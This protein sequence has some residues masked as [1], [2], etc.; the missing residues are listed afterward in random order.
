MAHPTANVDA[1]I[2]VNANEVL[3]SSSSASLKAKYKQ[4]AK[5]I[6]DGAREMARNDPVTVSADTSQFIVTLLYSYSRMNDA[7]SEEKIKGEDALVRMISGMR[8]VYTK[9]GHT[10]PWTISIKDDGTRRASGNPLVENAEISQLKLAHRRRV[11]E[12]RLMTRSAPPMTLDIV[13]DQAKSF[14]LSEGEFDRR[15]VSFHAI[16]LLALN[17]GL[18][19]AEIEKVK[20]NQLSVTQHGIRFAINEKTKNSLSYNEYNVMAWPGEHLSGVLAADRS[21]LFHLGLR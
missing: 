19:Y 18:R 21:L 15:D 4:A 3:F 2:F 1:P 6:S 5:L 11:A 13:V 20:M 10:G 7:V 9:S 8:W 16:V 17:C 14:W 12:L